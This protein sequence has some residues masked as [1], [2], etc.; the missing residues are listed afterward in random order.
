MKVLPIVLLCASNVFMTAAWYG[1]LK[2]KG[3][4]LWVVILVSW[5][6]AL[7]EY[8]LQVPANRLGHGHYSAPQL[9]LIQECISI[10]AFVVFS[11]VYLRETPKVT[12]WIGFFLVLCGLAVTLFGRPGMVAQG[13]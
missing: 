3:A 5:A 4:A 10:V 13:S 11:M 6:I 9:K 2:F 7:P 8:A 1:H 12:D